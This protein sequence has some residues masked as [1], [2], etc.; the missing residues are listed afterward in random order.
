MVNQNIVWLFIILVTLAVICA[1]GA[2]IRQSLRFPFEHNYLMLEGGG[3]PWVRF[4][5]NI[6]TYILLFNNLIPLRWVIPVT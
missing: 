3:A 4:P 1:F 5:L 2:L 6:L